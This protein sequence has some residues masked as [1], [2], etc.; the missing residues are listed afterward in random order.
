MY[1]YIYIHIYKYSKPRTIRKSNLTD[2]L[3]SI[4]FAASQCKVKRSSLPWAWQC[5]HMAAHSCTKPM[6]LRAKNVEA[7]DPYICT[8]AIHVQ[9]RSLWE[10]LLGPICLEGALA[11]LSVRKKKLK[12]ERQDWKI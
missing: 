7:S 1:I 6:I 10:T 9:D 11:V 4:H 3:F 12:W 2:K 5:F 8:N